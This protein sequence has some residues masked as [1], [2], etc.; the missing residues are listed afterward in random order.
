MPTYTF[1]HIHLRSPDPGK[2]AQYYHH[3]FDARIIETPQRSRPGRIDLDI[4]GMLVFIAGA[5]SPG[6]E[7]QGPT[8]PHYGMDHFGLRVEDID[9]AATELK[10]RG[11]EFTMEP[12]TLPSGLKIAFIRG[13]DDVR[14]ELVEGDTL[15]LEAE[16]GSS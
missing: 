13:P 6:Q 8:E 14:I 12:K 5:M 3:M 2:T 16:W 7:V 10:S 15:A 9:E 4:N 1:E 11:A